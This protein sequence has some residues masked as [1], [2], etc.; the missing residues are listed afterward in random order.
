MAQSSGSSTARTGPP[1]RRM[2]RRMSRR[3]ISERGISCEECRRRVGVLPLSAGQESRGE[4]PEESRGESSDAVLRKLFGRSAGTVDLGGGRTRVTTVDRTRAEIWEYDGKRLCARRSASV[5]GGKAVSAL[6]RFDTAGQVDLEVRAEVDGVGQAAGAATSAMLQRDVRWYN[7]GRLIRE[8]YDTVSVHV[9]G[10]G[11]L[12]VLP[13][14]DSGALVRYSAVIQEYVGGELA[15]LTSL[16]VTSCR[17]GGLGGA[18]SAFVIRYDDQG[19]QT[20]ETAFSDVLD[21]DCGA[22]KRRASSAWSPHDRSAGRAWGQAVTPCLGGAAPGALT[23][24]GLTGEEVRQADALTAGDLLSLV[25]SRACALPSAF[26]WNVRGHM[27]GKSLE[28]LSVGRNVPLSVKW[29]SESTDASRLVTR[30][31]DGLAVESGQESGRPG[32]RNASGAAWC[33]ERRSDHLEEV[34]DG[35]KLVRH[36]RSALREEVGDS[37]EGTAFLVTRAKAV[38]VE[39]QGPAQG[40]AVFPGGLHAVDDTADAAS[41]GLRET[42]G[43]MLR[44][45]AAL[46]GRMGPAR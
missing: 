44:E 36:A 43:A 42:G 24:L 29:T 17:E 25:F 35:A 6:T 39:A 23:L 13:A 30:R 1:A 8:M 5:S 3:D 41:R 32:W 19:R 26:A 9:D 14:A 20:G 34:Y 46:I 40:E 12:L 31:E 45:V 10:A 11:A 4:V 38:L 22:R 28:G 37:P 18:L 15:A 27:A 7:A 16:D 33:Y 2:K 21:P